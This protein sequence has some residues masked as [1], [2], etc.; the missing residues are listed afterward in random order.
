M[1]A[2]VVVPVR[3]GDP[4][5]AANLEATWV[6]AQ[7]AGVAVYIVDNGMAP[8][9]RDAVAAN[10]AMELL[11]CDT[12]GSYP[13]RN[14]G[15]ATALRSGCDAILFT[16]ADCRPRPGWPGHLL[17]LLRS[18]D[19]V[20]SVAAPWDDSA[21]GLGAAADYRVRLSQWAGCEL[22]CGAPIGTLD[23]RA[24]AVRAEVFHRRLFDTR[25][26]FAGDALFG[27]TARAAGAR[28][29]GC[30]HEVLRHDPPQTWSAEL[31][32]YRRIAA[33]LVDDLRAL[34][35]REVLQLLPEH[36]HLLLPPPSDTLAT[37]RRQLAA[38]ADDLDPADP[39]RA[40]ALYRA[41]RE[42]GWRSGWIYGHWRRAQNTNQS[43]RSE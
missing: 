32:K 23:T 28:V 1:R 40:A 18:A 30:H 34:S 22:R 29:I 16:D 35:R 6:A 36:A 21:L 20:T 10:G 8:P 15:V 17:D 38:A 13:A 41:V 25:L 5:I 4:H 9:V 27:R 33:C 14:V 11:Q 7:R 12:V 37:A 2:T 26:R 19:A 42:F 31:R 39:D 3:G 43:R 24:A